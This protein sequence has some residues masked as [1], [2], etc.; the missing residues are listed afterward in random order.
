ME[1]DLSD[2]QFVLGT[3]GIINNSRNPKNMPLLDFTLYNEDNSF[4]FQNLNILNFRL[5]KL[6]L[7]LPW[8]LLAND[9]PD[10]AYKIMKKYLGRGIIEE[11]KY[12]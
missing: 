12:L 9:Y 10:I 4:S 7:C 1:K 2:V 8:A 6:I 5:I 11:F 3:G